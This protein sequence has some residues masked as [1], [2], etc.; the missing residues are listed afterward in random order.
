MVK[1]IEILEQENKN[2]IEEINKFRKKD[3]NL[4]KA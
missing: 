2:L 1:K 3:I 4:S